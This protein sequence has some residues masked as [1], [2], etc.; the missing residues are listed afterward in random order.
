MTHLTRIHVP[1]SNISVNYMEIGLGILV[2]YVCHI[3]FCRVERSEDGLRKNQ[4]TI[5]GIRQK[6]QMIFWC[7]V[8][9]RCA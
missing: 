5:F 4:K 7:N 3:N 2:R 9:S 6:Y 1:Y 8:T